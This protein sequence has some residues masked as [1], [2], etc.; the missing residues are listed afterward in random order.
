MLEPE[1]ETIVI[2]EDSKDKIDLTMDDEAPSVHEEED[3]PEDEEV[4]EEPEN[5]D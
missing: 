5:E 1:R 2:D 4:K 3:H